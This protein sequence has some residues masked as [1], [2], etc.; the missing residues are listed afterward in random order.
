MSHDF[1][2]LTSCWYLRGEDLSRQLCRDKI[3]NGRHLFLIPTVSLQQRHSTVLHSGCQCSRNGFV[4]LDVGTVEALAL[5]G[6]LWSVGQN[7]RASSLWLGV[8]HKFG[9]WWCRGLAGF[10]KVPGPAWA[11]VR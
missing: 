3:V 6:G 2:R 7:Y 10:G 11:C 4:A 9:H 1:R 8:T 5:I